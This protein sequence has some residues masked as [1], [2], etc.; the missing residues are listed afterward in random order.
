MSEGRVLG[1]LLEK[2]RTVPDQYP[3]TLA[4]LVAACNQ[5]T[6]RSPVMALDTGEV[7]AAAVA[8]KAHG[9]A[10]L[11]HPTHGRGVVR[12]RQVAVDKLALGDDEAAALAVL[13]LRGPQ[14]AAEIRQHGERLHDFGTVDTVHEVLDRLAE[15]G[16]PLV[17]RLDRSAGQKGER[18]QQ[19]IAEEAAVAVGEAPVVSPSLA[20][21][22]AELEERVERLEAALRDLL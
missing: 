3:L 5:S 8:L 14:T 7:E 22:V 18:W 12:Y 17:R 20:A 10:R 6:S 19:V 2:E 13:L 15:R 1:C 4:S 11:V 16:E 21:R 9:W